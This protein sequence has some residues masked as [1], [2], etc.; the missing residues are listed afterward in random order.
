MS[1]QLVTK[2]FRKDMPMRTSLN[3]IARILV[4]E[5][6]KFIFS[7]SITRYRIATSI[8]VYDSGEKINIQF[9]NYSRMHHHIIGHS[10]SGI[11]LTD[12]L[13]IT[14]NGFSIIGAHSNSM[15][16]NYTWLL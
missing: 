16:F 4:R 15:R 14:L 2:M 8:D 11:M 6:R 12:S 10:N 9:D 1:R 7:D 5:K 13:I 3:D